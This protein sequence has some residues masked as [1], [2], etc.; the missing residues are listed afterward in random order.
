MSNGGLIMGYESRIYVVEK[1]EE[2]IYDDGKCFARLIAR[3]D[4]CVFHA[5]A[6]VMRYKPETNC[7]IYADD[8]NTR[9]LEDCYGKPLTEATVKSVIEVLEKAITNG[10]NYWRVFPLLSMLKAVEE[11]LG[12]YN[13]IVVLHYGY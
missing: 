10:E 3:F 11:R 5:L 6:N 7:Y 8:G 2:T 13:K 9:I 4:M 1:F 12:G